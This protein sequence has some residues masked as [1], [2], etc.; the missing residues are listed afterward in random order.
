M[1]VDAQQEYLD[2]KKDFE[3]QM[4]DYDDAVTDLQDAIDENRTR[5][6]YDEEGRA[7][8]EKWD[9]ATQTWKIVNDFATEYGQLDDLMDQEWDTYD[10]WAKDHA[11]DVR[12]YNEN[13]EL[14]TQNADEFYREGM[15]K[16]ANSL[17]TVTQDYEDLAREYAAKGLGFGSAAE[18]QEALGGLAQDVLGGVDAQQGLSDDE[19]DVYRRASHANLRDMENSFDKQIDSIAAGGSTMRTLAA[20][21]EIRSQMS[22]ARL[23]N[24]YAMLEA[25]FERRQIS[26]QHKREN[27]AMMVSTGL[28][29]MQEYTASV[30]ADQATA[31]QAFSQGAAHLINQRGI[32]LEAQKAEA[33]NI[34]NSITASIGISESALTQANAMYRNSVEPYKDKLA[35]ELSSAQLK[36]D[37]YGIATSAKIADDQARA[38]AEEARKR[39]K[40]GFWKGI[41]TVGASVLLAP[42]T[43]GVS[44]VALPSGINQISEGSSEVF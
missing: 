24:E 9:E 28:A 3:D 41:A 18:M 36:L 43:L 32:D 4:T 17:G 31:F 33:Q 19:K 22:D 25:D 30:R 8:I 39:R 7:R 12:Y 20:G 2:A 42:A 10:E 34:L 11:G 38:A 27:Y 40:R 23:R 1:S 13:G 15:A 5:T 16:Y 35:A 26:Y 14:V 29:T 44:L 21:D 6:T 37:L